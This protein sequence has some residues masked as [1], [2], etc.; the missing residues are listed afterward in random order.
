M[1]YLE[2]IEKKASFRDIA[3]NQAKKHKKALIGAGVVG[4]GLGGAYALGDNEQKK[5]IKN[6]T[7]VVAKSVAT[8]MFNGGAQEALANSAAVAGTALALKKMKGSNLSAGRKLLKAVGT[9]GIGGMA[10]GDIVGA[11]TIPTAQLIKKHKKEFNGELPDKKSVGAIAA[12]NILPTAALWGGL[13]G[14]K[15]GRALKTNISRGLTKNMIGLRRSGKQIGKALKTEAPKNSK[16]MLRQGT[17]SKGAQLIRGGKNLTK[18]V[19]GFGGA[20]AP[21]AVAGKAAELPTYAVTPDN[22][23][24]AKKQRLRKQNEQ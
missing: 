10:I 7:K 2:Y 12:A 15:N 19:I 6:G 22:V 13:Y 1:D 11:S 9:G 3:L 8:G 18:S 24:L 20:M 17:K 4:T 14:L 23:I 21:I 5:K 16:Q